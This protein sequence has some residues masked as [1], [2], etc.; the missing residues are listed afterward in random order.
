MLA[1][2]VIC[3]KVLFLGRNMG[4]IVSHNLWAVKRSYITLSGVL[5]AY[6]KCTCFEAMKLD[7]VHKLLGRRRFRARYAVTFW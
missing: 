4:K 2:Q 6:Q 3:V 5:V 1:L 7:P